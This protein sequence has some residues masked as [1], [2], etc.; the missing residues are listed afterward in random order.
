V[1]S[2]SLRIVEGNAAGNVLEIPE[3]GLVLGRSAAPRGRLGDDAA[4]SRRHARIT[5]NLDGT[6][7]VEDLGS[8]NGTWLNGHRVPSDV[9]AIAA[10]GDVIQVGESVLEIS[11]APEEAMERRP[12]RSSAGEGGFVLGGD[13]RADRGSIG[14]IGEVQGD[15][16]TTQQSV[17]ADRGGYAAGG[18]V[19]HS[20]RYDVDASGLAFW[21]RTSGLPRFLVVLGALLALTG[22]GSF[23]YP[24]VKALSAPLVD[25]ASSEDETRL[26]AAEAR[27]EREFEGSAW[28]RCMSR[29]NAR[30][31]PGSDFEPTPW[32][33]LGAGLFFVGAIFTTIGTLMIRR[34]DDD[35]DYGWR[36]G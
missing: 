18:D 29:A 32:M 7:V 34:R 28:A 31:G 25:T 22:V 33:P 5:P 1:P 14:A 24:I 17:R 36:G 2:L 26:A 6:L 10:P 15:V 3:Y 27:C 8:R 13:V 16:R 23:G 21:A 11:G 9:P 35:R 20:E 12:A 19:Y 4:L 30:Y